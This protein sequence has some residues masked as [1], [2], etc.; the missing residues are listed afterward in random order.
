M[1]SERADEVI[2]RVRERLTTPFNVE[3]DLGVLET[4][5]PREITRMLAGIIVA[6]DFEE[7]LWAREHFVEVGQKIGPFYNDFV[8]ARKAAKRGKKRYVPADEELSAAFGDDGA[9][10]RD[11]WPAVPFLVRVLDLRADPSVSEQD[12]VAR[13]EAYWADAEVFVTLHHPSQPAEPDV[14]AFVERIISTMRERGDDLLVQEVLHYVLKD[15]DGLQKR[16]L[17]YRPTGEEAGAM[18]AWV[19]AFKNAAR[20]LKAESAGPTALGVVGDREIKRARG[21]LRR[22]KHEDRERAR[23]GDPPLQ[24][25]LRD[26]AIENEARLTH[27]DPTGTFLTLT[28]IAHQL[29]RTE[30][31]VRNAVKKAHAAG[32]LVPQRMPNGREY[33][34]RRDVDGKIIE[35]FL[36]AQR[37][38]RTVG[39]AAHEAGVPVQAAIDFIKQLYGDP[40]RVVSPKKAIPAEEYKFFVDTLREKVLG[41]AATGGSAKPRTS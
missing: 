26:R 19:A 32:A 9:L 17:A 10:V 27:H 5:R 25:Q 12:K 35:R 20:D 6:F 11:A 31:V 41:V 36:G 30:S 1:G 22:W 15:A 40:E 24:R 37:G 21:T 7:L 14:K 13:E 34:F 3:D 4:R 23:A 39:A 18:D 29:G 33:A 38:M 8:K 2:R 16:L 28:Q